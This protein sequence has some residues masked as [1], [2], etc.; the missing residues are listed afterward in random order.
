MT[1][2][3]EMK[4]HLGELEDQKEKLNDAISKANQRFKI[5]LW[6]I[7]LGILLLPLYWSGV[8]VLLIAGITALFYSG[9]RAGYQDKLESVKTEIHELETCMV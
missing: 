2:L 5:S 6:G 9:K 1:S 4:T 8:P 7:G 3:S